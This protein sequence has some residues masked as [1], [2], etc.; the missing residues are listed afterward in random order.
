MIIFCPSVAGPGKWPRR[1]PEENISLPEIGSLSAIRTS[2]FRVRPPQ[3]PRRLKISTL[4]TMTLVPKSMAIQGF[5]SCSVWHIKATP[6]SSSG[7][8]V[9]PSM[10]FSAPAPKSELPYVDDWVALTGSSSSTVVEMW[11]NKYEKSPILLLVAPTPRPR[12]A[13]LA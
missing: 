13:G 8:S 2:T 11:G 1:V 6:F 5:L 7:R 3:H 10:H 9:S 12:P 4:W